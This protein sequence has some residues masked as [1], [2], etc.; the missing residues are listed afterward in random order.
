MKMIR[1]RRADRKKIEYKAVIRSLGSQ[2]GCKFATTDISATGL[3]ATQLSDIHCH[4]FNASSLVDCEIYTENGKVRFIAKP[5]RFIDQKEIAFKIVQ[6]EES[7]K[8][9]LNK[10]GVATFTFDND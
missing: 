6:I 7:Q 8:V 1:G 4:G 3:L 2:L 9:L 10:I 5:I